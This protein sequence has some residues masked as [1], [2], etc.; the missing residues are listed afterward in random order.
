[1]S[2]ELGLDDVTSSPRDDL[3]SV[4]RTKRL[5]LVCCVAD[6]DSRCALTVNLP[7]TMADHRLE[8]TLLPPVR[9]S[10]LGCYTEIT[11]TDMAQT[12]RLPSFRV[13]VLYIETYREKR[14]YILI[15]DIAG[16]TQGAV[17]IH[18]IARRHSQ[19]PFR[20]VKGSV[21]LVQFHPSKPHF[22]VAVC[23]TLSFFLISSKVPFPIS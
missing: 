5:V 6:L 7:R 14:P 21:Q 19:A 11:A 1:M 2:A 8:G 18:Q 9:N 17:W 15:N 4:E 13:Y 20:K 23:D 12:W 10:V 16:N 22:F 3:N